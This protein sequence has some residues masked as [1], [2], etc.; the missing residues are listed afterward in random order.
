MNHLTPIEEPCHLGGGG[1]GDTPYDGLSG[2][3]LR[4][5]VQGRVGKSVIS[6]GSKGQ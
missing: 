1:G 4:L 5:Q 3:K 6:V 2:G